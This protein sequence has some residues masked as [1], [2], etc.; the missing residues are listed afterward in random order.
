MFDAVWDQLVQAWIYIDIFDSQ[1]SYRLTGQSEAFTNQIFERL[2]KILTEEKF[3]THQDKCIKNWNSKQKKLIPRDGE[4]ENENESDEEDDDEEK[5][6][7]EEENE[8]DEDK[9][10]NEKEKEADCSNID[11]KKYLSYS[12]SKWSRDSL[13]R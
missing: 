7:D 4:N 11:R 13:P 5:I 8:D 6:E 2:F 1:Y 3:S 9:E 12:Y 10:E